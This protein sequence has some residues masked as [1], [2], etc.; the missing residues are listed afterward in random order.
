MRYFHDKNGKGEIRTRTEKIVNDTTIYVNHVFRN[1]YRER[2]GEIRTRT[3]KIVNDTT[4]YVNHV[5]RN[6]Y[7]E[8]L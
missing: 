8:R 2:K 6:I 4:I 5:F 7:R 3:E 1:I